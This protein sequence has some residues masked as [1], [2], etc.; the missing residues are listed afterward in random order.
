MTKTPAVV[1]NFALYVAGDVSLSAAGLRRFPLPA[2]YPAAA[3]TTASIKA[4]ARRI[5]KNE[6]FI[7][8]LLSD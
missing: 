1:S 6:R 2:F 3:E 8:R 7:E 4:A 5:E